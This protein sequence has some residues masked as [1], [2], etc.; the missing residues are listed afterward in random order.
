MQLV[1]FTGRIL[2]GSFT[3]VWEYELGYIDPHK[4]REIEDFIQGSL[5][6]NYATIIASYVCDSGSQEEKANCKGCSVKRKGLL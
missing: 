4:S 2:R 5:L 3:E 1:G 6:G